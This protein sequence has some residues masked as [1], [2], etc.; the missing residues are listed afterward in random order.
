ML[1]SFH[2]L[3]EHLQLV[4]AGKA[5]QGHVVDGLEEELRAPPDSYDA[6][7][8]FARR[9]VELPLPPTGPTSSRTT[10]RRSGRSATPPGRSTHCPAESLPDGYWRWGSATSSSSSVVS[11]SREL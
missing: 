3:R 10:W 11:S 5:E 4:I 9:L 6:L 1:P 2:V 7:R 8:S